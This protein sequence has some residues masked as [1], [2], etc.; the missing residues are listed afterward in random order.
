[1]TV[2]AVPVASPVTVAASVAIGALT[3][4][5]GDDGAAFCGVGRLNQSRLLRDRIRAQ[6]AAAARCPC[7][8]ELV[9]LLRESGAL[10]FQRNRVA[11]VVDRAER[12]VQLDVGTVRQALEDARLDAVLENRT[13]AALQADG[14]PVRDVV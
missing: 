4:L 5:K 6:E 1:M 13:V 10:V 9:H 11:V 2:R 14:P 12:L 3:F 7:G 8:A